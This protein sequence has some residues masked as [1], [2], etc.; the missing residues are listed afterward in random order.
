[1]LILFDQGT[2]VA[3]RDS[4]PEHTVETARERGWSTLGFLLEAPQTIGVARKMRQHLDGDIP[5]QLRI[6]RPVHFA[7]PACAEQS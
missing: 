3:I 6:A 1:M 5:V 7:H 2:P 4:L